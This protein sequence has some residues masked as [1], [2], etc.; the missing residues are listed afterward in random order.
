MFNVQSPKKTGD[1]LDA[2]S[3]QRARTS[4]QDAR[5]AG[6]NAF[7]ARHQ[8]VTRG[9]V[10]TFVEAEGDFNHAVRFRMAAWPAYKILYGVGG[11]GPHLGHRIF[12]GGNLRNL[13]PTHARDIEFSMVGLV[14]P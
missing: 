12:D 8:L 14:Y 1:V 3:S 4:S 7:R 2:P 13:P 11:P 6:Y 10:N 9:R 5:A